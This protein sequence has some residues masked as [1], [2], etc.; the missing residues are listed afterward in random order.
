[1]VRPVRIFVLVSIWFANACVP[2]PEPS[3]LGI[4][5][6]PSVTQSSNIF[7]V[8]ST[9]PTQNQTNV[10]ITTI[11]SF[12]FSQVLNTT[13]LPGNLEWSPT[14]PLTSFTVT[15]NNRQVSLTPNVNFANGSLYTIRFKKEVQSTTGNSMQADFELIFTTE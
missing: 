13:T 8:E 2:K 3:L 1:M 4:L 15:P 10:P 5:A 6:L 7:F 14:G 11:L 9:T 12:T